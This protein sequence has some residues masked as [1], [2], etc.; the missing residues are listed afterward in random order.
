MRNLLVSL[1]VVGLAVVGSTGCRTHPP[2]AEEEARQASDSQDAANRA[3]TERSRPQRRGQLS[4]SSR[5]DLGD[6]QVDVAD[7]EAG[8]RMRLS[9]SILFSPGSASL[10]ADAK[11]ALNATVKTIKADF[12]DYELV[13]Q[14][15]TDNQPIKHSINKFKS[16]EELSVSRAQAVADFLEKAGLKNNI[17]VEGLGDTKP[18][19]DNKTAEGRQQNRRVEILVVGAGSAVPAN[20]PA[21]APAKTS[22]PAKKAPA[23]TTTQDEDLPYTGS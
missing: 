13:V 12:P 9:G 4:S 20:P 7:T 17:T 2:V 11:H 8:V 18:V 3:E 14:G 5:K 19:G 23:K 6:N 10:R 21:K 1:A 16:N 22:K 15:H